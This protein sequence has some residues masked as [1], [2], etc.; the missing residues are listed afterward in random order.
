MPHSHAGHGPAVVLLHGLGFSR[1]SWQPQIDALTAAG[2]RVVAPDLRGF[3]DSALPDDYAIADLAGDVE[4]LRR[5]QG[6]DAFDLVGHSMGGMVALSYAVMHPARVRSLFLASTT[7]HSGKRARAFALAMA[8]LSHDGFDAVAG[9]AARWPRIEAS[10]AEVM[11]YV[12]PVMKLLRKLSVEADPARALAWKA[13]ASFS[14]LDEVKAIACPT[15][16]MHGDRDANIPFAAGQLLAEAIPQARFIPVE[17]GRHNLP[18][19][20]VERFAEA[21]RAHLDA[22]R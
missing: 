5:S 2:Y 6:I 8:E 14:V 9:D 19:E 1:R 16:V 7:C 12:G 3:G 4:A 11:P 15:T 18:I 22:T 10:I 13:I 20:E 17:G 21:L